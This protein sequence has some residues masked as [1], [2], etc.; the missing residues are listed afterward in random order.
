VENTKNF[1]E[2]EIVTYDRE[3]LD[4]ETAHTLEEVSDPTGV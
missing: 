1:Q 2:P 3:E 4:L